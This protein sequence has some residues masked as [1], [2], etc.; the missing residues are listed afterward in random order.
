LEFSGC[1]IS[2]VAKVVSNI[3]ID[4]SVKPVRFFHGGTNEAK[5]RLEEFISKKLYR[6][7]DLR[8][9]P[10]ENCVSNLSP[11]LHLGQ[12]SPLYVALQVSRKAVKKWKLF[13]SS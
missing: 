9:D 2:N 13:L 3:N 11:Y 12:I 10:N 4:H 5:K 6:Y 1:D 8:N 7:D